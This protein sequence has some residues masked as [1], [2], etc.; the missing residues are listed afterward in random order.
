MTAVPL[1]SPRPDRKRLP[2]LVS[3]D[4]LSRDEFERRYE[5]SPGIRAE[6]IEGMVIVAHQ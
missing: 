6:L 3:G 4:R 2:P 5:A 1:S